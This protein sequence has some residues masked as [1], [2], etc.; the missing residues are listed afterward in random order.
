MFSKIGD[1]PLLKAHARQR[2]VNANPDCN[3]NAALGQRPL[4]WQPYAESMADALLR[5]KPM[6]LLL[7]QYPAQ[8]AALSAQLREFGVNAASARFLP[9]MARG[10]WVAVLDAHGPIAGFLPVDGFF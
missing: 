7:K 8:A 1:D 5:A 6:A 9:V 2:H 10:N 3:A 4:F